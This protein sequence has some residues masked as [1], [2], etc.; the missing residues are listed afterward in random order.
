[1]FTIITDPIDFT[2]KVEISKH[3]TLSMKIYDLNINIKEVTDST[4]GSISTTVVHDI[5]LLSNNL[6]KDFINLI[7]SRGISFV[8][9]LKLVGLD[10][11]EFEKTLLT[12]MDHYLLFFCT[13]K[14]NLD[15]AGQVVQSYLESIYEWLTSNETVDAV[16]SA[17]S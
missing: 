10:F 2:G 8:W 14:F 4:I 6:I 15:N 5:F 16:L 9:L 12:P 1:L 11:I 13:P 3:L 17:A 7:F